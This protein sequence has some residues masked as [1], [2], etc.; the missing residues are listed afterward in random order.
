LLFILIAVTAFDTQARGGGQGGMQGQGSFNESGDMQRDRVRQQTHD[1]NQERAQQQQR[2][3]NQEQNQI[4]QTTPATV[5][6]PA[7]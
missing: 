1:Q 7:Q 2:E 4:R 6:T 5:I 3:M